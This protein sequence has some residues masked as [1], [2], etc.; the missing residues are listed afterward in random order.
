M[1]PKNPAAVSLGRLGGSAGKGAAKRRDSAHYKR[2][3]KLGAAARW[4]KVKA[5]TDART[6]GSRRPPAHYPYPLPPPR[7]EGL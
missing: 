4:A 6:S 2:L 7:L 3:A 5:S 1:S